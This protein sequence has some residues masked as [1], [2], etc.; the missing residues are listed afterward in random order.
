MYVGLGTRFDEVSLI[1]GV[2]FSSALDRPT[3][4]T[5]TLPRKPPAGLK[6]ITYICLNIRSST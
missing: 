3:R 2:V 5:F 1:E 6:T 4:R